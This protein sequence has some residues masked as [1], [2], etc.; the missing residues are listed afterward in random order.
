MLPSRSAPRRAGR[1]LLH[2]GPGHR[3]GGLRA[4]VR[5]EDGEEGADWTSRRDPGHDNDRA[6]VTAGDG[7]VPCSRARRGRARQA[8]RERQ[9]GGVR[10]SPARPWRRSVRHAEA[11]RGRDRGPRWWSSSRKRSRGQLANKIRRPS[12]SRTRCR[13]H[14]EYVATAGSPEHNK[15][16]PRYYRAKWSWALRTRSPHPAIEFSEAVKRRLTERVRE[17]VE[18]IRDAEDKISKLDPSC[19][20]KVSED[21]KRS[22]AS[23]LSSARSCAPWPRSSTP[24]P[25]R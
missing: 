14:K 24:A 3:G 4:E 21:Y 13:G 10:S 12:S 5:A 2:V 9:E 1:H 19:G 15:R 16:S 17:A 22:S 6:H 20:N 25:T 8:H 23:S 7:T 18:R 11:G